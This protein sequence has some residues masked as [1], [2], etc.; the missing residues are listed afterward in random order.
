MCLTCYSNKA[1]KQE[2]EEEETRRGAYAS[3]KGTYR[4]VSED[5]ESKMPSGSS[6]RSLPKISLQGGSNNN[7]KKNEEKLS[8]VEGKLIHQSARVLMT[9]ERKRRKKS[10][11]EAAGGQARA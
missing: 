6:V 7:K 5:N 2:R 4:N 9:S 8:T 10:K 1:T 3:V 11:A